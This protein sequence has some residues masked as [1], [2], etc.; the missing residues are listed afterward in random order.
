MRNLRRAPWRSAFTTLAVALV[1]TGLVAF[2]GVIDSFT[3]ALDVAEE[4]SAGPVPD[5]VAVSLDGFRPIGSL[6]VNEIA[7]A[8]TV[9]T[10]EPWVRVGATLSSTDAE[11]DVLI[12]LLDLEAGMWRPS[13]VA[14]EPGPGLIL[15]EKAAAD[16]GVGVGDTITVRHP[17]RTGPISFAYEEDRLAVSALHPHPV[18]TFAYMDHDA[19]GMMGLEGFTNLIQV[20]PAPGATEGA[21]QRELFSVDAVASVQSVT[22]ATRS[23]SDFM[24]QF[25]GII[26]F[27]ALVV[28]MLAALIAFLTAS[29]SLD[30]RVREHATMFAF[31]VRVR[32]ALRMAMTESFLMGVVAT[33]LGMLGGLAVVWWMT[34]QLLARSVPDFGLEVTMRPETLVATIVMG[35]VAVAIAPLFTVRRM[36]RMDIPGT[37]RLV[38]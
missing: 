29:I 13:I 6:E 23:V 26:Q 34:S 7:Q 31:G 19:A 2:L 25:I 37:L 20:D 12:D 15:A 28:L 4:E 1:I 22:A 8:E 38:E 32:T 9:Q 30:A 11:L 36:R 35:V 24:D 16:L 10:A 27:M 3:T 5:R 18:R 14:G 21:V 33:A 17:V